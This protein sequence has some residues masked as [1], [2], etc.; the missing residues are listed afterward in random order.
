MAYQLQLEH[1]EHFSFIPSSTAPRS[2]RVSKFRE[3]QWSPLSGL[4]NLF[5]NSW[6]WIDG[7]IGRR[8]ML[9]SSFTMAGWAK[10]L[11]PPNPPSAWIIWLVARP[12]PDRVAVI[13]CVLSHSFMAA[14]PVAILQEW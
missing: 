11:T 9:L 2:T 13:P 7:D 4:S 12:S 5:L 1:L 8:V 3:R 14:V 10:L 6:C